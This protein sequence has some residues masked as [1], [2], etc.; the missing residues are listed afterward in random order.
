MYSIYNIILTEFFPF[1]AFTSNERKMEIRKK[2]VGIETRTLGLGINALI[3][4][5][6]GASINIYL[7][8]NSSCI[9]YMICHRYHTNFP[10]CDES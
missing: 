5:A 4:T 1:V 6:T 9:Y 7:L 3:L 2:I 10:T 8:T